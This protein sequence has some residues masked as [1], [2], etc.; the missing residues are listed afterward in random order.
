MASTARDEWRA[1]WRIPAIG[2]VGMAGGAIP[3][4]TA[5]VFMQPLAERFGWDRAGFSGGLT[6]MLLLSVL[7]MPLLGPIVDRAGPRRLALI[8]VVVQTCGLA[9]L[10]LA[11]GSIVQW[12]I[13]CGIVAFTG[14]FVSPTIWTTA[15][16]SRFV[17][18]RGLAI[19]VTLSG[20]GLA[21]TV[22]P[23]LAT[24]YLERFGTAA[25]YPALA[26]S[27][28]V[29]A[30]PLVVFGFHP[31]RGGAAEAADRQLPGIGY[32][33]AVLSR[34]FIM[35]CIAGALFTLVTYSM[36]VHLVPILRSHGLGTGEAAAVTAA[37]GA[38]SMIGRLTG[39]ALLDRFPA[40]IVGTLAFLLPVA[41]M[42]VLDVA[43][44]SV[45]LSAVVAIVFGLA[46]GAEMDLMSYLI[47]RYYGLRHFAAIS[48]ISLSTA[49]ASAA[50]GP[51]IAGRLYD[52]AGDYHGFLILAMVPLTLGALLI[53]AL[54]KAGFARAAVEPVAPARPVLT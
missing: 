7:I 15:A 19:S 37:M 16:A 26:L 44:N 34:S 10:G 13:L 6:I 52:V 45:W 47:A 32:R 4:V 1:A 31:D 2:L 42:A 23:I 43:G 40:K 5:G 24:F 29:I 48:A 53:A 11:S 28:G 49:G 41:S 33:E 38:A 36:V 39:G 25:A 54:P 22:G 8:G 3:S 21:Q 35:L 9:S 30:I 14:Q 18:S 50:F 27:W 17:T 12:W 51:A 20:I 46:N